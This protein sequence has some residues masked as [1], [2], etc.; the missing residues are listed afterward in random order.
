MG[1]ILSLETATDVCSVAL[2]DDGQL[3]VDFNLLVEKAHST[4]LANLVEKALDFA[5]S[6]QK[7]L[8]AVAV[9]KGPGSYT[10]LRI[11]TSLA[12]GI[13]FGL[14]KPLIAI[15]TLEALAWQAH[16]FFKEAL[17]CPMIDA[18]RMEVYHLLKDPNFETIRETTNLVVDENSFNDLLENQTICFFGN[19]AGKCKKMLDHQSNAIFVDNIHASASSVGELANKKLIEGDFEDLAYFEPFYLKEFVAGKPK[20]LV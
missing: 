20:K 4:S 9:S 5:G 15:N 14:D 17:L 18:R 7:E 2:H 19:G 3:I 16:H 6:N 12:K 13:C 1:L 8:D 11:G 10:G